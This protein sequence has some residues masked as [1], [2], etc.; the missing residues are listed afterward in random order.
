MEDIHFTTAATGRV[1]GGQPEQEVTVENLC[2]C[3]QRGVVVYCDADVLAR[4]GPVDSTKISVLEKDEGLC[5]VDS[6]W[7]MF[8]GKPVTFTYASNKTLVFT[9]NTPK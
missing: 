9:C 4:A 7:L 3:P 6:G 8:K 2:S 1:V 5:L